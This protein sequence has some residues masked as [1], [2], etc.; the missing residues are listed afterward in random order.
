MYVYIY[1]YIYVYIYVYIYI[2]YYIYIYIR[3]LSGQA[4][5]KASDVL[6]NM[7]QMFGSPHDN[8]CHINGRWYDNSSW[9]Y[10][11]DI[12]G[13]M[14]D[15]GMYGL[16]WTWGSPNSGESKPIFVL[17]FLYS[18]TRPTVTLLVIYIYIY[19]YILPFCSIPLISPWIIS[20]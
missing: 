20:Q 10:L 11:G 7:P 13:L 12:L 9:E 1:M 5:A 15:I 4:N 2:Y 3:L 16:M 14:G 17:A 8:S 6:S 18:Q 19:H